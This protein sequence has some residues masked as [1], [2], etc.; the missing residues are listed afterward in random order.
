MTMT[1]ALVLGTPWANHE[2]RRLPV[3][4]QQQLETLLRKV[5]SI[6]I[7]D[8]APSLTVEPLLHQTKQRLSAYAM[9]SMPVNGGIPTTSEENTYDDP[10]ELEVPSEL[11]A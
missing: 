1:S 4:H 7:F 2:T 11:T 5:M 6:R 8:A 9:F 10:G 3:S